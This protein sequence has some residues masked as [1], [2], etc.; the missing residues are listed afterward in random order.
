MCTAVLWGCRG[1]QG[2]D[3]PPGI[4]HKASSLGTNNQNGVQHTAED[5]LVR[6]TG[7]MKGGCGGPE[8]ATAGPGLGCSARLL[9]PAQP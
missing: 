1:N 4:A 8:G 5:A 9:S 6:N 3:N 2:G 7:S